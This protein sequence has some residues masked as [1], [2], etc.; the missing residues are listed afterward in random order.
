MAI[1]A[2]H[3]MRFLLAVTIAAVGASSAAEARHW[4]YY[5]HYHH[6]FYQAADEGWG[7][8]TTL[9]A[10]RNYR[11]R[12]EVNGFG[13][14]IEQMIGACAEQAAELKR[15]P[16]DFVAR[17]VQTNGQQRNALDRV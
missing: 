16:F 13:R 1:N 10:I 9:P 8:E 14:G 4:R 2:C 3:H 5:W 7:Q 11:S 15:M 17:I 6:V 12:I